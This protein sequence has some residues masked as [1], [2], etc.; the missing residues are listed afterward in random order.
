VVFKTI[1]HWHHRYEILKIKEILGESQVK[2]LSYRGLQDQVAAALPGVFVQRQ[3]RNT[4]PYLQYRYGMA[5]AAARAINSGELDSHSYEQESVFAEN[6]TQV[7]Y[8]EQDKE[9]IRLASQLMGVVPTAI[10]NTPS[11][12]DKSVNSVSPVAKSKRNKYGI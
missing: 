12:E 4:D 9:T 2:D 5:V 11:Q 8:A 10:D 1:S 3:L 7:V 6:L